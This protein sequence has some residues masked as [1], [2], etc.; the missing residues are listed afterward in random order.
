MCVECYPEYCYKNCNNCDISKNKQKKTFVKG[1]HIEGN[2]LFVSE[3]ITNDEYIF[4]YLGNEKVG[5]APKNA[6]SKYIM[7]MEKHYIDARQAGTKARYINHSKTP[8]AE[9]RK[10]IIR[11]V[12][13]CGVFSIQEIQ[14]G[15]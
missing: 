4:E 6:T 11:G 3:I 9:F 12:E 1:S 14:H 8:N 2:G 5:K 15:E 10:R 13:R 7:Q